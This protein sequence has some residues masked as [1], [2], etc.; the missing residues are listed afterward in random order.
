MG[1]LAQRSG[2]NFQKVICMSA[3]VAGCP[4]VLTEL[5]SCGARFVGKGRIIRE[6]MPCDFVGAVRGTGQAIHFDAKRLG[7]DYATIPLN[8]AKMFEVH[9]IMHLVRL[10][11]AGAIA[12][13]LIQS[14]RIGRYC[15][16]S[17]AYFRPIANARLAWD[18]ACLNDLGPTTGLIDFTRLVASQVP[19]SAGLDSPRTTPAFIS[20]EK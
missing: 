18:D 15:W 17:A 2:S 13:L 19:S 7:P 6:P 14:D 9:Q 16:F 4:I 11:D 20:G 1:R 8:N 12:G 10:A 3:A 5:P